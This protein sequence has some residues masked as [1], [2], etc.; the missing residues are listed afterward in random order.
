MIF[1][2]N[3][4]WATGKMIRDRSGNG[5]Q[6]AYAHNSKILFLKDSVCIRDRKLPKWGTPAEVPDHIYLLEVRKNG[7]P[8]NPLKYKNTNEPGI[9]GSFFVA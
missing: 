4:K 6:T 2:G 9:A 7:T 1:L 3:P 8:E 5:I